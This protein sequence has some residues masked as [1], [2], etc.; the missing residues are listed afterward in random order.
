M[1]PSRGSVPSRSSASGTGRA[2]L[3]IGDRP[4]DGLPPGRVGIGVEAAG[5]I[6]ARL[7]GFEH[8][9]DR[10]E[11]I[12]RGCRP[13]FQR[14]TVAGFIGPRQIIPLGAP[15]EDRIAETDAAGIALGQ[16][17]AAEI[18]LE[19]GTGDPAALRLEHRGGGLD[20]QHVPADDLGDAIGAFL[21][22]GGEANLLAS[23]IRRPDKRRADDTDQRNGHEREQ[24]QEP[25]HR[26][27]GPSR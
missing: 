5:S 9:R 12:A 17:Q 6:R 24:G 16:V 3:L 20:H 23:L 14:L 1:K 4:V 26:P 19:R 8:H 27:V 13:D 18:G 2:G 15:R 21:G 22:Q 25:L 10:D 7:E 11:I